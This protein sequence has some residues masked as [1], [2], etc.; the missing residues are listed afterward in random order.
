[1]KLTIIAGS[2]RARSQSLKVAYYLEGLA[3]EHFDSTQ[4][5]D[6]HALN[7]P[8]WNEGV[9]RKTEE[10]TPWFSIADQL[11]ESDAFI[12]ITPE[13]HGM[14]T[15]ALK[16]FLMLTT[17]KELAHKPALAVSVSASLNGVY[18]ISELRMTA[19]KNNHVCLIPDHLI[20]RGI[21]TLLDEKS[22]CT[23]DHMAQRSIYTIE[24]LAAYAHALKPVHLAMLEKGQ[25]FAYGM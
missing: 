1:M 23:N 9:W 13:W 15:P 12:F 18:P 7:L 8:L 14:V 25:P 5:L 21:E 2:Q 22:M 17:A 11:A 10:W 4:V 6:L 3:A 24:L 20:F 16:N 19:S